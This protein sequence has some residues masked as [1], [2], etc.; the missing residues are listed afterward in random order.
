MAC[1]YYQAISLHALGKTSRAIQ[2]MDTVLKYD[3][4]FKIAKELF[5]EWSRYEK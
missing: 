2:L 5:D 3:S 1:I 4:N